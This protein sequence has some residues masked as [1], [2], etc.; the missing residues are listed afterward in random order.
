MLLL[1]GI[2]LAGVPLLLIVGFA[3]YIFFGFINDDHDAR[4]VFNV[5]MAIVGIGVLLILG[6]ILTRVFVITK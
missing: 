5:A 3:A 4:A 1:I 2:V 6:D